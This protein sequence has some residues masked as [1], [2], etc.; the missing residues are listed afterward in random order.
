MKIYENALHM[1]SDNYAIIGKERHELAALIIDECKFSTEPFDIL[2]VAYAYLWQGAKFRKE[3]I[4]YFE[5]YLSEYSD[6]KISYNCINKWSIYS[7]LA[8]LY[9]KEYKYKEAIFCLQKCITVDDHS[10]VA[11]YTRIGDILVKENINKAEDFYVKLLNDPKLGK[12]KRQFAY[13]LDE[14]VEKKKR[15]YVYNPRTSEQ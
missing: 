10:N 8:T 15:G 6:I 14:V 2:G 9:E 11:D 12:Y 1:I 3:A 13:A 7:D 5:K 4:S